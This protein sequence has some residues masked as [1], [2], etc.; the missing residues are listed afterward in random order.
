MRLVSLGVLLA[1]AAA[2]A[3]S[4]TAKQIKQVVVCGAAG[5]E[6]L[7]G[8]DRPARPEAL[9][10][11][12]DETSPPS[13]S[14]FYTIKIVTAEGNSWTEVYVPAAHK[15]RSLAPVGPQVWWPIPADQE[16]V[17]QN[18]VRHVRPYPPGAFPGPNDRT[19]RTPV[20]PRGTAWWPIAVGVA[21]ALCAL[22]AVAAVIR[23]RRLRA[24]IRPLP[25]GGLAP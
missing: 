13:A 24:T 7:E 4:A 9:I 6:T 2:F 15:V 10:L 3:S 1:A 23:R 20:D 19:I 22:G 21:F 25:K 16:P 5:C 11:G 17:F 14:A 18:A 8:G 12:N